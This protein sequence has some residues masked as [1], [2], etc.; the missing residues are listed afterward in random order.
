MEHRKNSHELLGYDFMVDDQHKVW[1]IEVN[2]SPTMEYS[3]VRRDGYDMVGDNG[4]T[5]EGGDGGPG[6]GGGGLQLGAEE[7]GGGDG[8][9]QVRAPREAV[10]GEDELG[11]GEL[12]GGREADKEGLILVF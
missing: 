10:R 8:E 3:T 12:R 7:E 11:G 4:A 1:L 9:V 2:S 5:G 6:E